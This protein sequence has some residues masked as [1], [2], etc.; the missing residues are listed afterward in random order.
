MTQKE[1]EYISFAT[2]AVYKTLLGH[3]KGVKHYLDAE[4]FMT[5]MDTIMSRLGYEKKK[6]SYRRKN[7][8]E[9]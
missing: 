2:D 7:E 6:G 5:V 3:G 8:N 9:H 1:L 4:S